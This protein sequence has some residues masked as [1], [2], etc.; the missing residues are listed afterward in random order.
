[1]RDWTISRASKN[2]RVLATCPK[3]VVVVQVMQ[4]VTVKWVGEVK[5]KIVGG[6][7]GGGGGVILTVLIFVGY[8]YVEDHKS[9]QDGAHFAQR[10]EARLVK[11]ARSQVVVEIVAKVLQVLVE[12]L[13][14]RVEELAVQIELVGA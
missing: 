5:D 4:A 12:L 6:G 1:M 2:N 7:S 14:A 13:F 10:R 8:G 3:E 9:L 11:D